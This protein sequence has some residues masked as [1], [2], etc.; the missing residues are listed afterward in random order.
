MNCA[1]CATLIELE[2]E[3]IGIKAKCNYASKTLEIH[4]EEIDDK[5]V[6]EVVKKAGYELAI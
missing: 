6:E 2:F 1:S 3:D 4:N 5:K